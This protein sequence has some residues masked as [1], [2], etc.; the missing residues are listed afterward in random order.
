LLAVINNPAVCEASPCEPPDVLKR[1]AEIQADIGYADGVI[2]GE[3]G[4]ARFAAFQRAGELR[5]GWFGNGLRNPEG[6]EIHLIVNDHGPLLPELGAEM[7]TTYRGGCTD[8]S[9]PAAFPDIA[10][11]DGA[12]GPNTC[13]LLQAAIFAPERM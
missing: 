13:R 9:I 10:K 2:V 3:D 11:A 12:P 6:A 4:T 5:N 1:T 8:E 7:V